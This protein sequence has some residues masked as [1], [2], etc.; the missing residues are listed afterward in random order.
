MGPCECT[1][2]RRERSASSELWLG[3][4]SLK[5]ELSPASDWPSNLPYPLPAVVFQVVGFPPPWTLLLDYSLCGSI[6]LLPR[7]RAIGGR[8]ASYR[9]GFLLHI[10]CDNPFTQCCIAPLQACNARHKGRAC[11]VV[12]VA[13]S[14]IPAATPTRQV[15]T[16][17]TRLV[18]I[19]VPRTTSQAKACAVGEASLAYR[20]ALAM[21]HTSQASIS[22]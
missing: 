15:L 18:L 1:L 2:H 16:R 13:C 3:W 11:G 9:K 7:G 12:S 8:E 14:E 22:Y 10:Q 20:A 19:L 17:Q 6:V 21:Y 4:Y 5:R